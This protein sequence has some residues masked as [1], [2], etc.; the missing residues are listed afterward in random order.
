MKDCKFQRFKTSFMDP[1][2]KGPKE[3]VV[4]NEILYN[5]GRSRL[6][7]ERLAHAVEGSNNTKERKQNL[8]S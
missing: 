4:G 2:H 6:D 1:G 3:E 7:C 5:K 8:R